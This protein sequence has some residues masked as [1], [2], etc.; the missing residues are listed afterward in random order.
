MDPNQ[1]GRISELALDALLG[2][3]SGDPEQSPVPMLNPETGE[4]IN[5]ET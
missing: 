5:Y 1:S 4:E 2:L 3:I